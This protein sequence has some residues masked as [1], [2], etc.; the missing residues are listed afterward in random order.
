MNFSS[1]TELRTYRDQLLRESDAW[2]LPD[3]PFE[4]TTFETSKDLILG[5][6]I[7]LRDWPKSETDLANATVPQKP[8]L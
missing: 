6:R 5:Y 7:Q 1:I 3:Y 4:H 2:F 8:T